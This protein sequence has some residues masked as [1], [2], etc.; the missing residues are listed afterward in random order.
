MFANTCDLLVQRVAV[1]EKEQDVATHQ[2]SHNSG[3]IHA[4][5]YYAPGSM[6]AKLCVRGSKLMYE[7]CDK[8]V[9]LPQFWLSSEC[10]HMIFA[11]FHDQ[12]IPA[13][14]IGKLIVAVSPDEVPRLD[15]YYERFVLAVF[16][17]T[18]FCV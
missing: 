8:K 10:I 6:R 18:C 1:V 15:S 16:A 12:K 5:I 2:S 11:F 9:K 17:S 13:K 14:R 3:V 4:G 7:Y